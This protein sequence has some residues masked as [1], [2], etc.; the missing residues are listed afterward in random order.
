[1]QN[2]HLPIDRYMYFCSDFQL[3]NH[4]KSKNEFQLD[5]ISSVSFISISI[6]NIRTNITAWI[7]CINVFKLKAKVTAMRK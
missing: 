7:N 4:I 2:L 1:M 5:F 3:E 6:E